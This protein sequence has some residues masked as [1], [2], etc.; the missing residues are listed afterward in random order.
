MPATEPQISAILCTHNRADYLKLALES[1]AAQSLASRDFE[2]L[3]VD[4]AS[5]DGT[6]ALTQAFAERL[7][8]L[9]Y[10]REEKLGLSWARNAGLAASRAPYL[11]YLDDDARAEPAWLQNLLSAFKKLRPPPACVGGRVRLDWGQAAPAWLPEKFYSL[12]TYLDYGDGDFVLTEKQYLVG[13]NIAFRRDILT[14]LGGFNP[15]LGRRGN[16]LLSG[17]EADIV[18]RIRFQGLPVYYAGQAAVLHAVPPSRRSRRWLWSRLFW[19]GASQPLIDSHI[20]KSR[21]FY[22][23]QGFYDL[24]RMISFAMRSCLALAWLDGR[25]SLEHALALAQRAGRL[26]SHVLLAGGMMR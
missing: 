4:N 25:G 21:G 14:Q 11:A 24:R 16:V 6:A 12:Y 10:V 2:I 22:V 3:V 19:D 8:N 9:R 5:S 1:L 23:R 7:P 26:R 20:K 18:E 13:A 17:E 15:H